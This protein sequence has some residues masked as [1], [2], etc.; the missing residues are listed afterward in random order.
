MKRIIPII[1]VL[2]LGACRGGDVLIEQAEGEKKYESLPFF[3]DTPDSTKLKIS[4]VGPWAISIAKGGE[5][6]SVS[7][8]KG[9][10]KTDS[11]ISVYVAENPTSQERTTSLILSS[12]T[13]NVVYKISQR[14]GQEWYDTR[15]WQ[16]TDLQKS[17]IRG[18]VQ[19]IQEIKVGI[20]TAMYSFDAKGNL[21]SMDYA[22]K[23]AEGKGYEHSYSITRQF[24]ADGHMTR[25]EKL[26]LTD[27]AIVECEYANT[28]K[29]VATDA[30]VTLQPS[31]LHL[32]Q[33]NDF[34]YELSAKHVKTWSSNGFKGTSDLI[35]FFQ[36][37]RLYIDRTISMYA[38]P[39]EVLNTHD[40]LI[41]EYRNEKPY[42]C[43]EVTN[44]VYSDN[45]MFFVVDY[46][47]YRY[48]YEENSR[49][50]IVKSI[51]DIGFLTHENGEI[52]KAEYTFNSFHDWTEGTV[53]V[54]GKS[55]PYTERYSPFYD[56]NSNWTTADWTYYSQDD[57]DMI[58]QSTT[59]RID[60]YKD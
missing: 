40:T 16:R 13:S 30:F 8:N 15:Y 14:A 29:L 9:N 34:V 44:V 19:S 32:D 4:T 54:K 7:K 36:D 46:L 22:A 47:G 2:A 45:D 51:E 21:T 58:Q 17:G 41:W 50:M 12:G 10:A 23:A 53:T 3:A 48:R 18:K 43:R 26:G 6:C 24:D 59:R 39:V 38:G 52:M 56:H 55:E 11:V 37:N 1:V 42:S 27:T 33:N 20:Y 25:Y 49:S 28:G 5:W 57:H 31:L 35:Y 60:Y